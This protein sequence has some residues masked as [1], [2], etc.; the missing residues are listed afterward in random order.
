MALPTVTDPTWII[1][2]IADFDINGKPD[3]VWRNTSSGVNA[4]WMMDGTSIST[5]AALPAVADPTWI[6]ADVTDFDLDSIPDIVWRNTSSGVNVVWYLQSNLTI[7][8]VAALPPVADQ[9]WSIANVADFDRDGTPDIIWRNTS[10]GVNAIWFL[11]S[12][13]SIRTV[14]ALPTVADLDWKAR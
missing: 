5:V 11:R 12:D 8:T 7:R 9:S 10:S 14:E 3:I 2:A 4:V 6:I 1:A 13:L